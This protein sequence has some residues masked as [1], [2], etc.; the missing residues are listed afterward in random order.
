MLRL[1]RSHGISAAVLNE[2][3][4]STPG[5]VIAANPTLAMDAEVWVHDQDLVPWARQLIARRE[6]QMGSMAPAATWV[7]DACGEENPGSFDWCWQC[8]PADQGC[9]CPRRGQPGESDEADH[10]NSPAGG[11]K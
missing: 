7:C 4:A 8:G 6:R 11:T 1:L 3:A 2:Q 10:P 9:A 5:A